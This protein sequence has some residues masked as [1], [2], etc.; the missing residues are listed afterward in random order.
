MAEVDRPDADLRS[1]PPHSF[2]EVLKV[3]AVQYRTAIAIKNAVQTN[4]VVVTFTLTGQESDCATYSAPCPRCHV[5][6]IGVDVKLNPDGGF[7]EPL[8]CPALCLDCEE[9]LDAILGQ[10]TSVDLKNEPSGRA[11]LKKYIQGLARP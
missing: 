6:E 1:Q 7:A 8:A 10:G 11:T 4:E 3:P 5:G 9:R 2:V